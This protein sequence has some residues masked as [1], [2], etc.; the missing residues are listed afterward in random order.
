MRCLSVLIALWLSI[1]SF[2][3]ET[4]CLDPLACNFMEEGECFFIDENGNPC[5]IE[6]CTIQGACNY[7]PEADL[8]DGSCEF[9]SCLGCTDEAACNYDDF[10]LYN[11]GSC[12]Y[13]APFS[14]SIAAN[15]DY[16]DDEFNGYGACIDTEYSFSAEI[17][18]GNPNIISWLWSWEDGTSIITD[19]PFLNHSFTSAGVH[20]LQL[21]AMDEL[22][23]SNSM[24]TQLSI[25]VTAEIDFD[26]FCHN[27]YLSGS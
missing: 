9:E 19:S 27:T 15:I 1:I 4:P 13:S 14:L 21:H 26:F 7:D 25:Y 17:I 22:G 12:I 3:S 8:Y 18:E 23:C 10:A 5:V 24:S 11:D 2:A 16:F 20:Q 6:G